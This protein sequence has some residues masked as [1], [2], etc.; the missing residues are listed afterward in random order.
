M[1]QNV[2]PANGYNTKKK[3]L[4]QTYDDAI[5]QSYLNARFLQNNNGRFTSLDPVSR[6]I[7]GIEKMPAYILMM[8]Q[9]GGM[10]DQNTLLA[11]PQLQNSY[12]YAKNNPVTLSDP[13]GQNPYLMAGGAAFVAS[14]TWN[15]GRD[16]VQN[17]K[18]V[19]AG[20]L[21]AYMI[22]QGRGENPGGRYM[23]DASASAA[24]AIGTVGAGVGIGKALGTALTVGGVQTVTALAGG[25]LNAGVGV[26]MGDSYN[27]TTGQLNGVALTTDFLA[28]FVGTR[29]GQQ[30]GNPVGAPPSTIGGSLA[31]MRAV[32]EQMRVQL[33]QGTQVA[34]NAVAG[35]AVPKQDK[36]Q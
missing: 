11:D 1:I 16:F 7:G 24:L 18:D 15:L 9:G 3:F 12:S 2:Q 30:I 34:G 22:T 29:I 32:L 8:G 4:N 28:G 20:A 13:S 25:A 23:K 10:I 17:Y 5:A 33:G 6:D 31:S 26:A 14:V 19:R 27:R 35:T 36:T 21:P